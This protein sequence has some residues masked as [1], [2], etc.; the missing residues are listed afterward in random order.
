MGL[1]RLIRRDSL[2]ETPLHACRELT[3]QYLVCLWADDV[4]DVAKF[5]P[6]RRILE[7]LQFDATIILIDLSAHGLQQ[8]VK[9]L[10]VCLS[11]H[12]GFHVSYT[13]GF[14]ILRLL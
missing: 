4:D 6:C 9:N 14:S 10:V 11:A 5:I 12:N 7:T 3:T 1:L 2:P 8:A 13:W